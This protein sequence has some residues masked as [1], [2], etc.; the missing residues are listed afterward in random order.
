MAKEPF[1]LLKQTST[2]LEPVGCLSPHFSACD[3]LA[4]GATAHIHIINKIVVL[5]GLIR[6]NN[7]DATDI[8][9]HAAGIK[10]FE[11]EKAIYKAVNERA[12]KH[13]NILQCIL[14]IPEGI[15]HERLA[16]T[17]EFRN[18]NRENEPVS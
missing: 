9:N 7:P 3:F 18:R 8:A 14:A 17:L 11:H 10:S 13:P 2:C 12:F 1:P 5:K 6:Y 15:F 4:E 16:T